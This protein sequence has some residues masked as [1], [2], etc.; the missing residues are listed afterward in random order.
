MLFITLFAALFLILWALI[1]AT[2][3]ALERLLAHAA[4]RVAMFRYNDYVPVLVLLV[5]GIALAIAAG[6]AFIDI[7]ERVAEE[8]PRLGDLDAAIHHWARTTHGRWATAFFV[9]MTQLG[10]PVALGTIVLLAAVALAWRGRWRWAAYLIVTTAVGALLNLQLKSFFS[11][12]RPDL[13]EALREATGYAFPS[14]H[15][16]GS[17]VVFGALF[18]LAF[19]TIRPWNGRAAAAALAITLTIAIATSRIYLG[20]HWLSD[21]AGGIAAGGTWVVMTTLAYETSRRVRLV[22]ALRRKRAQ[23]VTRSS[24]ERATRGE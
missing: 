13:A 8:S 9:L 5:A 21:I 2:G 22:R 1:R 6:D 12:E 17:T 19:R 14:G 11:R 3:P 4:H 10:S 7:A 15:A 20:V 23:S 18:Y 24:A 16:M